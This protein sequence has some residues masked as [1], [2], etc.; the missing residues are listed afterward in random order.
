MTDLNL[1]G[2]HFIAGNWLSGDAMFDL[3]LAARG[4]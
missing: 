4:L 2:Q 3:T 1:T